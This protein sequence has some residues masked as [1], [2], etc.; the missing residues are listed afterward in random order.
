MRLWLGVRLRRTWQTA[1]SVRCCCCGPCLRASATCR[2]FIS[3]RAEQPARWPSSRRSPTRRV[4]TS[5]IV[6]APVRSN[7][8]TTFVGDPTR[9]SS[10]LACGQPSR[11]RTASGS[12][13]TTLLVRELK[14]PASLLH[15]P[16]RRRPGPARTG[17]GVSL[18]GSERRRTCWSA[19]V[20]RGPGTGI[21]IS[22][23]IVRVT[24]TGARRRAS[25]EAETWAPV[26]IIEMEIAR[27]VGARLHGG[28]AKSTLP[29][30]ARASS[31]SVES[32]SIQGR[33]RSG[34]KAKRLVKRSWRLH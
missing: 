10:F 3:S 13:S 19:S 1:R 34:S 22:N 24:G 21:A 27:S 14:L 17:S 33:A 25:T 30:R 12:S 26:D 4:V 15:Q 9:A 8:V 6:E 18:A 20:R 28:A 2:R 31:M 11:S 32:Q 7:E 23:G 5:A 29:C 16:A